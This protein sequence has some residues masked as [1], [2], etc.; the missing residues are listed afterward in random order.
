M[1]TSKWLRAAGLALHCLIAALMLVSGGMNLLAPPVVVENMQKFGLG[2]Y[3][4]LIGAGEFITAI[5]LVVPR[6]ASLGILLTS[7]FFGGAIVTHMSHGEAFVAQS[8]LLALTWLGAC[9]RLPATFIS[10][11][12]ARAAEPAA[13]PESVVA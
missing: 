6:T 11:A 4:Y 5:L 10:F 7:G 9:L 1:Q 3:V 12:G 2:E 13:P 8:V